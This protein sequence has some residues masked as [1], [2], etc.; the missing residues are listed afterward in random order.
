[1]TTP[2]GMNISITAVPAV[3][4]SAS[5]VAPTAAS[6]Y[7]NNASGRGEQQ[8]DEQKRTKEKFV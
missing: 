2:T 8:A 5:S 1:M 3:P 4:A 7:G 6:S